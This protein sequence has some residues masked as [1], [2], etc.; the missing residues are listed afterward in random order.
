[1]AQN[2]TQAHQAVSFPTNFE[3]NSSYVYVL[4]DNNEANQEFGRY[5]ASLGLLDIDPIA[6]EGDIQI[7]YAIVLTSPIT[8]LVRLIDEINNRGT[9]KET[10]EQ[11]EWELAK[12]KMYQDATNLANRN[13]NTNPPIIVPG[14][15]MDQRTYTNPSPIPDKP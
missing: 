13:V 8:R 10:A 1:M 7:R 4:V 14:P 15:S 5:L 6:Y 9:A 3:F 12:E 2:Q 11:T